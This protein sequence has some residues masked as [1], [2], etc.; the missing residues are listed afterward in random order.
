MPLR[1][2]NKD[3]SQHAH[4]KQMDQLMAGALKAEYY[5]QFTDEESEAQNC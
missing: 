5:P 1:A 2:G 4:A 3:T